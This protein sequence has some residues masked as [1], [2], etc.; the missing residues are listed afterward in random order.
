V[1]PVNEGS[2][3]FLKELLDAQSVP[4]SPLLDEEGNPM[5]EDLTEAQPLY[6]VI[7][8]VSNLVAY[9]MDHP[10]VPITIAVALLIVLTGKL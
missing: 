5:E 3:D 4:D 1:D 10:M 9:L 6:R 2:E 7:N 8:A